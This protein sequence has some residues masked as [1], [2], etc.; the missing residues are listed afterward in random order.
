MA[1]AL[2]AK[3]KLAVQIG[4]GDLRQEVRLAS[5]EMAASAEE[6]SAQAEQLQSAIEFFK[7]NDDG[8]PMAKVARKAKP[9][10]T[11]ASAHA[12]KSELTPA[13]P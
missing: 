1:E 8:S 11:F 6:L 5:E 12:G 4:D 7:V 10:I 13:S 2:D 3:A 9:Q